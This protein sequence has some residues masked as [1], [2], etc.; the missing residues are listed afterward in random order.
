MVLG[1]AALECSKTGFD[2][3]NMADDLCVADHIETAAKEVSMY[4]Y[5]MIPT[6]HAD[7][8]Y[9]VSLGWDCLFVQVMADGNIVIVFAV[10][11]GEVSGAEMT[12]FCPKWR[13]VHLGYTF[14]WD[15]FTAVIKKIM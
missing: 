3:S 4:L 9:A 5:S 12:H 7:S 10:Q 14:P 11:F 2:C 8:N 1:N 6:K 13:T 15:T